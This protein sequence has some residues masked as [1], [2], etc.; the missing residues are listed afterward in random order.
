MQKVGDRYVEIYISNV[1]EF[2]NHRNR[3]FQIRSK[4]HKYRQNNFG[5]GGGGGGGGSGN[6]GYQQPY[7]GGKYQY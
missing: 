3:Q 2:E 6:G 5:G 4:K 7:G 1:K